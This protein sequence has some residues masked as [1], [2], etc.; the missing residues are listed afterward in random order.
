MGAYVRLP[1]LALN[2]DL[3]FMSVFDCWPVTCAGVAACW[4]MAPPVGISLPGLRGWPGVAPQAARLSAPAA[5][6]SML[7]RQARV[8]IGSLTS[9]VAGAG[10]QRES[11]REGGSGPSAA[12]GGHAPTWRRGPPVIEGRAGYRE[13][14]A[15][16]G[17]CAGRAEQLRRAGS[18]AG[19]GSQAAGGGAGGHADRPGGDWQEPAGVAGGS[20]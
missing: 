10:D 4:G 20:Y 17:Q 19:G 8:T 15:A 5:A 18:R 7:G 16:V 13:P 1:V 9:V 3:P 6:Q 2:A 11:C 14:A 12:A